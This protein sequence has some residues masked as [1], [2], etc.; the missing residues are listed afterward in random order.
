MSVIEVL[1]WI[2]ERYGPPCVTHAHDVFVAAVPVMGAGLKERS[3]I[4]FGCGY[5]TSSAVCDLYLDLHWDDRRADVPPAARS[6]ERERRQAR[7][8]RR[9]KAQSEATA[10]HH[11]TATTG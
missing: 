8:E 3:S 4:A 11:T 7:V 6:W 5:D 2:T 1:E 10:A 9:L